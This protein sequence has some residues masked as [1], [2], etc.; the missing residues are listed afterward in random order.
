MNNLNVINANLNSDFNRFLL[1]RR[2]ESRLSLLAIL[3]SRPVHLAC[4]DIRKD[5]VAHY[6]VSAT[7]VHY[8][9]NQLGTIICQT[10]L[11]P[12]FAKA[13]D[14]ITLFQNVTVHCGTLCKCSSYHSLTFELYTSLFQSM[15]NFSRKF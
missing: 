7:W 11:G 9:P 14:A 2:T 15:Q 10:N 13:K 8:L 5:S 6:Q 4:L 1:T 12:L 3:M